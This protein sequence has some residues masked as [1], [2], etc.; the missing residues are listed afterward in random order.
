MPNALL[1]EPY[2]IYAYL[3]ITE[4]GETK[5][6]ET[7]K[8]P[9]TA[10]KEPDDYIF[11]DNIP[12]VTYES[13]ETE[14]ERL[15][16]AVGSPLVAEVASDMENR[17]RIYV[18]VGSE[19]GY[20]AGN[21]YYYDGYDWVSGGVYNSVAAETDKTLTLPDRAA[22][23]EA[24]GNALAEKVNVQ[25]PVMTGKLNFNGKEGVTLGSKA[26]ALGEDG[27]ATGNNSVAMNYKCSATGNYSTATG[28]NTTASG[29]G[30]FAA[31][32]NTIAAGRAQTVIGQNNV[33]DTNDVYAFI[34]GNGPQQSTRRNALT[35]DWDGNLWI[36]GNARVG[37]ASYAYGSE[38]ATK[39]YVDAAIP[40][41][42]TISTDISTDATSDT[43]TASPKAVKTYADSAAAAVAIVLDS[44]PTSGS[45]NGVESGGVFSALAGKANSGDVPEVSNDVSTD[46]ASTTKVPS[47]KAIKDY[48]DS[49][50][51]AAISSAIGG[52]Y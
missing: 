50:I 9:V 36:K 16:A 10:A 40:T 49:A 52:S 25:N 8:I 19:T 28:Y 18:Y 47:V 11:Y 26:V 14:I 12:V 29:A 7:I 51:S 37:G 22:D 33:E 32:N 15:R 6:V 13:L 46:A 38:L 44:T 43:K 34:I 31:N 48:V 20:T 41:V 45:Q 3:Q 24:T 5:T 2:P 39:A 27:T 42:P 4:D 1:T 21:W 35:F 30:S 23:A 17:T